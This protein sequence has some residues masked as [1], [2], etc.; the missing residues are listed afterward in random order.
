MDDFPQ[1]LRGEYLAATCLLRSYEIL[2]GITITMNI[3]MELPT[4]IRRFKR[5][6]ETPPRGVSVFCIETVDMNVKGL[7]QAGAWNY[8]REEIT[9]A[10]ERRRCTRIDI[11]F[12]FDPKHDYSDGMRANIVSHMLARITNHC[13]QKSARSCNDYEMNLTWQSLFQELNQWRG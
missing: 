11:H 13:F 4:V 6:A 7:L 9:V 8:L 3:S 10:L 12:S 1:T 2:T 5:R